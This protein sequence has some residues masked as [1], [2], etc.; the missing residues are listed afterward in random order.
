MSS[1]WGMWARMHTHT[2]IEALVHNSLKKAL[3]I[4]VTCTHSDITFI[5]GKNS[6]PIFNINQAHSYQ[7]LPNIYKKKNYEKSSQFKWLN[8]LLIKQD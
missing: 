5:K 4:Q 7:S 1:L 8:E 6:W 2:R 3:L